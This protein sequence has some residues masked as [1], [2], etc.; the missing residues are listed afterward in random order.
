MYKIVL[1]CALLGMAAAGVSRS[2]P[3]SGEDAHAEILKLVSD[4]RPD[5]FESNL[6]TSNGISQVA[7]GD[8]HGNIHGQFSWVSPEGEHVQVSY[9]ADENGY[10]PQSNLLPTPPPVPEEI[11]RALAWIAAHPYQEPQH[12]QGHH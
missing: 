2:S 9:V 5:G 6:D 8:V 11:V 3:V 4:V 1:I 7:S 12:G 10:Q